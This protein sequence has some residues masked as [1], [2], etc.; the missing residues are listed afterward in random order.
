M[1]THSSVLAWGIPG[2]GEPRGLTSVGS[3]GVRH[4]WSDLAAVAV[5]ES[6]SMAFIIYSFSKFFGS[7]K[8]IS[9]LGYFFLNGKPHVLHVG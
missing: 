4:D 5:A 2:M 1:A 3:H 7:I 9:E 6:L 8:Y